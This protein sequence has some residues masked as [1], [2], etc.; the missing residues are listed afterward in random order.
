MRVFLAGATGVVGR[1]LVPQ[2]VAEGHEVVGTSR[3]ADK[4]ARLRDVGAEGVVLDL[5]DRNAARAAVTAA[6]PE[7]IMH[8]AT[9]LSKL[10]ARSMRKFDP[11]LPKVHGS[12][13]F[14]PRLSWYLPCWRASRCFTERRLRHSSAAP[15]KEVALKIAERKGPALREHLFERLR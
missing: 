12:V 11:L 13:L 6:K 1:F 8:Q 5:L 7:A 15:T 9:A 14:R 3:S 2:L 4:A 10:T